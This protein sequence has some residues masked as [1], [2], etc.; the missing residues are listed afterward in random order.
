MCTLSF[1][2]DFHQFAKTIYWSTA[3][4]QRALSHRGLHQ[5]EL[6]RLPMCVNLVAQ[7]PTNRSD[8]DSV[9]GPGLQLVESV[10]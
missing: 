10:F 3:E 6:T 9:L 8:G 2:L 7:G 1:K 4:N 5:L